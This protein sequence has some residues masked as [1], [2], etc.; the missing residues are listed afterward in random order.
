MA[1]PS[2]PWDSKRPREWAPR[3]GA[4]TSTSGS[5]P[6]ARTARRVTSGWARRKRSSADSVA[7]RRATCSASRVPA[8]PARTRVTRGD[9]A[10]NSRSDRV[11]ERTPSSARA[12]VSVASRNRRPASSA[13]AR[14]EA[15]MLHSPAALTAATVRTAIVLNRRARRGS[16]AGIY[17]AGGASVRCGGGRRRHGT[18]QG[19]SQAADPPT[20]SIRTLCHDHGRLGRRFTI[21]RSLLPDT[22]ARDRLSNGGGGTPGRSRR[23]ALR[24]PQR[25]A[26]VGAP[27][28]DF[29]PSRRRIA[30][31][32][33][34]TGQPIPG[35]ARACR[36]SAA[37]SSVPFVSTM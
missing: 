4:P 30:D 31:P 34:C 26:L 25:V 23:P 3:R 14:R 13:A 32:V 11:P 19:L 37:A 15:A 36:S 27:R 21:R 29:W 28:L 18:L 16:T 24:H 5:P 12:R 9:P 8:P 2:P 22:R 35:G 20:A 1:G 6:S 17:R 10:R 7:S 33:S